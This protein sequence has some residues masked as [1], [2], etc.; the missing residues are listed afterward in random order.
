MTDRLDE[1]QARVEAATDHVLKVTMGEFTQ[2]H[3]TCNLDDTAPCHLVCTIHPE[4]GCD[5]PDFEDECVQF[6]YENGCVVAEWVNDGGIESV[7]FD[8]TLELPV[9]YQW[10][11]SHDS[12]S[13]HVLDATDEV[14]RLRAIIEE[15]LTMADESSCMDC[16]LGLHIGNVLAQREEAPSHVPGGDSGVAALLHFQENKGMKS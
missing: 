6:V 15:A 3:L 14:T 7:G 11:A 9:R 10:N 12:P 16:S 1:I 13:I 2:Y 4:G 8:H 5:D